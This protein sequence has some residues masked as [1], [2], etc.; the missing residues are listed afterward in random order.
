[1]KDKIKGS[2]LSIAIY[3]AM[4]FVSFAIYAAMYFVSF[5]VNFVI[6]KFIFV[7]LF[8]ISVCNT[9]NQ[10]FNTTSFTT[11]LLPL[12]YALICLIGSVFFWHS[13]NND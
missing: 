3:A 6:A 4:H 12:A 10:L 2:L 11:Q 1:M 9:L 8:G 13:W 5:W 7:P